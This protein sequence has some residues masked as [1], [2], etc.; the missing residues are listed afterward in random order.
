MLDRSARALRTRLFVR[1]PH[2][3]VA[4]AVAVARTALATCTHGADTSRPD[5]PLSG[6]LSSAMMR[7]LLFGGLVAAASG[8]AVELNKDTFEAE[9]KKS[10][11]NAF[12]KFLAP[13]TTARLSPR[14]LS[15]ARARSARASRAHAPRSRAPPSPPPAHTSA[16]VRALQVDE[17][18]LG[19]AWIRVRVVEFCCCRGRRLHSRI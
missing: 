6:L 15:L 4:A 17:A 10:G 12:V 14:A 3:A 11:K 9:V 16:V 18:C 13:V 2:G 1:V 7:A 19:P 8:S 5:P